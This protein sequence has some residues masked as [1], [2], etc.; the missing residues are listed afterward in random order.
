MVSILFHIFTLFEPG[1]S[2][3]LGLES[4]PRRENLLLGI[5]IRTSKG[6]SGLTI[7]P[8]VSMAATGSSNQAAAVCFFEF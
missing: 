2:I 7:I 5:L 1:I 4:K 6:H 8:T 3:V